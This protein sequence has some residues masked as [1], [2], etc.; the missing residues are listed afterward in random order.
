MI[1]KDE[2]EKTRIPKESQTRQIVKCCRLGL[3]EPVHGR[4]CNVQVNVHVP[5]HRR[6]HNST[7]KHENGK[8]LNLETNL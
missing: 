6:K 5:Y 8:I 2:I 7:L 3:I 1:F 4:Y